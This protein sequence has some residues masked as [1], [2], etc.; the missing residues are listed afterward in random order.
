[1]GAS[2]GIIETRGFVAAVEAA[3]T[4]VK[5]AEVSIIGCRL[6]GAGLVSIYLQGDVSSVKS[7]V[8]SGMA[9]AGRVGEVVAGT[10]IART[11]EGL[12]YIIAPQQETLAP[13]QDCPPAKAMDAFPRQ[14]VSLS[15]A[16]LTGQRVGRLRTIARGIANLAID[17]TEIKIARK[18]QLIA[19][20]LAAQREKKP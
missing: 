17:K 1:M 20:I 2:L 14:D 12:E 19:A 9:A 11:A 3:D 5:T 6:A 8:A 7:A 16:D 4:A 15:E 10:V 18:Q 13:A